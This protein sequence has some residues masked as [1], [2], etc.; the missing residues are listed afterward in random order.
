MQQIKNFF[1]ATENI[2]T[3]GQ[4][5]SD[6]FKDIANAGYTVVINLAMHDSTNAIPTEGGLVS[7]LGM[8]YI[9]MPVPFDAPSITH[10]KKFSDV[11]EIFEDQKIFVHCALN[12]RVSAFMHRYLT[13]VKGYASEQATS[14]ILVDWSPK[15]DDQWKAIMALEL[16][17]IE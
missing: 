7:A 1:Q 9:H 15:M 8:T 12:W 6:Q 11:M 13:L 5:S 4:P 16:R 14:T 2:G 10:V 17:D 3:A